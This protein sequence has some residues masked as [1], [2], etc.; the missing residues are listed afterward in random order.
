MSHTRT[1]TS[2]NL[3]VSSVNNKEKKIDKNDDMLDV[4]EENDLPIKGLGRFLGKWMVPWNI[5]S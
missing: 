2:E 4:S 3:A 5:F 1:G